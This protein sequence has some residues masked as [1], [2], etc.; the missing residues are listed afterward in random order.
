MFRFK[1]QR[2]QVDLEHQQQLET[3]EKINKEQLKKFE[4][5]QLSLSEKEVRIQ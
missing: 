5:L 3:L 2:E 1:D 4:S